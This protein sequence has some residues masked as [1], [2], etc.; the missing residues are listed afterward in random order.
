MRKRTIIA[1]ACM[2][3]SVVFATPAMATF[4]AEVASAAIQIQTF[5]GL[6]PT[7]YNTGSVCS[8]GHLTLDHTIDGVERD[9]LVW[10]AVLSAKASGARMSFDYDTTGDECWIRYFAVLPN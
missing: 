2:T 4:H 1:L 9:K 7:L 6:A 10:A 5:G 3:A 8:G